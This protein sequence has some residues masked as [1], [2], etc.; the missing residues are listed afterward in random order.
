MKKTVFAITI[1]TLLVACVAGGQAKATNDYFSGCV[2][3]GAPEEFCRC[4]DSTL[5]KQLS[6]AEYAAISRAA[7]ESL[8]AS[9]DDDS[10]EK[11]FM[12]A[13]Y[14]Q[15]PEGTTTLLYALQECEDEDF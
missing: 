14:A 11:R 1:V 12:Q 15:D 6:D 10:P 8:D 13:K 9:E 3:L 2:A 4:R 7:H 5:K